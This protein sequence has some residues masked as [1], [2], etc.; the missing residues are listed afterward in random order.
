VGWELGSIAVMFVG[1][2][3]ALALVGLA[4]QLLWKPPSGALAALHVRRVPIFT[5][6]ILVLAL[7]SHIDSNSLFHPVHLESGGPTTATYAVTAEQAFHDYVGR[8]TPIATN[9][10]PVEPIFVIASAGGGGRAQYWTLITMNCL[11]AD[12]PPGNTDPGSTGACDKTKGVT[13]APRWQDVFLASGISG[14]SVG[15]AMFDAVN[16]T[17]PEAT[18][19]DVGQVFRRGFLDPTFVSLLLGDAPNA[20]VHLARPRD[21]ARVLEEAWQDAL[22]ALSV[23]RN[24]RRVGRDFL[25]AQDANSKPS[26]P[27]LMLSST[28]VDDGCRINVSALQLASPVTPSRNGLPG[29]CRSVDPFQPFHGTA[30][31]AIAG[32]RD[33]TNYVC[34]SK[35]D[36][37]SYATAA[38]LSARFPFV[39]PSGALR[40]CATAGAKTANSDVIY[41]VDGGYLDSTAASPLVQLLQN[42]AIAP[43][44]VSAPPSETA[45]PVCYQPVVLQIDNGY[46][47]SVAPSPPG[48]PRELTAPLTGKSAAAGAYGDNSE[49]ELA[50]LA[51]LSRCAA[52]NADL[53]PTYLHVVPQLHPGTTAPLGWSLS[54]TAQ[55]DM[56]KE[57]AGGENQLALCNAR[58]W[59]VLAE[60]HDAC[61]ALYDARVA[62][63]KEST[64]NPDLGSASQIAS[65]TVGVVP[66]VASLVVMIIELGFVL[67][68]RR[69]V[70]ALR[71]LISA[72]PV[73]AAGGR[74]ARTPTWKRE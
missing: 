13:E 33:V 54:K 48:R 11:F 28:D 34:T 20:F 19:V 44:V 14:G 65:H 68:R 16:R 6:L 2:I 71:G 57:L 55:T 3:A 38:L 24:G 52:G 59:L 21:R 10:K 60:R 1:L 4:E 67:R 39:S 62:E 69:D 46:A 40:R 64:A 30:N 49:Q 72:R 5:V 26:F 31:Q 7:E 50:E 9:S 32:T 74:R 22:P 36:Y 15:L 29:T 66:V 8:S 37:L 12:S 17:K 53:P 73:P 41:A 35:G 61:K 51:T 63:T 43:P 18:A 70:G 58:R 45:S 42:V 25:A 47:D 27:L 23:E 56:N